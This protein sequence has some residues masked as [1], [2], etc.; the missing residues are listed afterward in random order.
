[1]SYVRLRRDGEGVGKSTSRPAL[2]NDHRNRF[3]V[4]A[5]RVLV[6]RDITRASRAHLNYTH[7]CSICRSLFP[8]SASD[9]LTVRSTHDLLYPVPSRADANVFPHLEFILISRLGPPSNPCSGGFYTMIPL[10]IAVE[11]LRQQRRQ[12]NRKEHRDQGASVRE[13]RSSSR[14]SMI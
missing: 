9:D 1:M 8:Q 5:Y 6:L 14:N 12:K 3:P 2:V 10:Q 13:E 4:D 11:N 7:E